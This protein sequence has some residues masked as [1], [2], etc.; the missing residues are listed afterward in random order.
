[1]RVA[2]IGATGLVGSRLVPLLLREGH[3]VE[4]LVRR[5]ALSAHPRL[6][7]HLADPGEW[8]A[9]AARLGAEGAISALGTTMRKAGS[10]AGFRAVD[11]DMVTA[12]AAAARK[13]GARRFVTVSSVGAD[14]GSRNFY[15]RIKA[16]MEAALE[17]LGFERLDVFRPGLLRGERGPDRRLGE[18]IGIALS[19]LV[20]LALRGPLSRFAAIDSAA[21]AR[22]VAASIR[23]PAPGTF[24]HHNREILRLAAL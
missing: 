15:L 21:V 23:E 1:V 16:E 8:P 22:A 20:N 4:A 17:G 19:P 13:S 14:A 10:E 2:L 24:V 5:D 12:F 11:L 7:T 6:R 18:R 9:I 3:E